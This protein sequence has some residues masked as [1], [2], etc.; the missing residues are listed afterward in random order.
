MV[1][2]GVKIPM[3]ELLAGYERMLLIRHFEETVLALFKKGVLKGTTHLCAGQEAVAVG[4]CLLLTGDDYVTST[5]RGHG[6]C[7]AKG[8]SPKKLMSEIFGKQDGYCR[9]RGGSQHIIDLSIGF[10]GSNGIT[11]GGLPIALGAAFQQKYRGRDGLTVAFIGDG[12]SNQGTFHET[13]NMASI[14]DLPLVVV[15]ENN[16]Y[17]MHTPAADTIRDGEIAVRAAA[18]KMEG[19]RVDGNDLEAVIGAFRQARSIVFEKKRPVLIEALTYRKYGHSKSDQCIY[20]SREEEAA[21]QERCPIG[22]LQK[23]LLHGGVDGE[24]L[25]KM[26]GRVKRLIVEAVRFAERSPAPV[27]AEGRDMNYCYRT[28]FA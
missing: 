19:L 1:M 21:W 14:W 3:K 10:L 12:A 8:G 9:G 4:V 17:A 27:L 20:R 6:H 7:L 13:L 23:K 25:K 2:P 22:L 26:E 24:H 16:L 5:H 28:F 18:Y 15:C 11:G